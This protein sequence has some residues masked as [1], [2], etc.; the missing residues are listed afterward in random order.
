MKQKATAKRVMAALSMM[1]STT[2]IETGR[3]QARELT[4][5]IR[6]EE[7][8]AFC[9]QT[10][11]KDGYREFLMQLSAY[12]NGENSGEDFVRFLQQRSVFADDCPDKSRLQCERLVRMYTRVFDNLKDTVYVGR[13]FT[14]SI[15]IKGIA[16]LLDDAAQRLGM[17][18]VSGIR[19]WEALMKNGAFVAALNDAYQDDSA[20]LRDHQDV[21][22][23]AIQ[24]HLTPPEKIKITVGEETYEIPD[25]SSRQSAREELKR[26]ASWLTGLCANPEDFESAFTQ[27]AARTSSVELNVLGY[28]FIDQLI[29]AGKDYNMTALGQK[30]FPNS[31]EAVNT[32]LEIILRAWYLYGEVAETAEGDCE[33]IPEH[34]IGQMCQAIG[35]Y[36]NETGSLEEILQGLEAYSESLCARVHSHSNKT[37]D[38]QGYGFNKATPAI[39]AKSRA[40]ARAL[41]WGSRQHGEIKDSTTLNLNALGDAIADDDTVLLVSPHYA[42]G[43]Q[44]DEEIEEEEAAEEPEAVTAAPAEEAP[45]DAADE[46]VVGD[47]EE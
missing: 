33:F 44:A 34:A 1:L 39:R 3:A 40:L 12:R 27:I 21:F 10:L 8:R 26:R 36:F 9:Q 25:V 15:S 2:G 14:A 45:A 43:V 37:D 41:M 29:A 13:G 7:M 4:S 6:V 17:C 31:G 16:G 11:N 47:V 24:R 42:R 19:R 32:V 28:L 38:D 20:A 30:M 5:L 18:P 22:A 46:I 23:R 35:A